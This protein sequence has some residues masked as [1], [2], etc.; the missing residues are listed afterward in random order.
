MEEY[1]K[2]TIKDWAVEDRPREKMLVKG[3]SS[4]SD[5]EL[6]AILI[7]AGS[8]NAS[9]V[10]I[11]KDILRAADNSLN[12]LGKWSVSDFTRFKGIGEAKAIAIVSALELGR[13]RNYS[14]AISKPS[15]TSS[16]DAYELLQPIVADLAHE[17]FW[18]LFLNRANKVVAKERLSQ[19][20]VSGTVIDAKMVMKRG[21]ELLASS[22]IVCHNHPSGQVKPSEADA[23]IT[24]K[25]MEAGRLMDIPVL[26][27]VIIAGS[28]YYSFMDNG[29]E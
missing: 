7:R 9:A 19:G 28:D 4:L 18:A 22:I 15:V 14:D 23:V 8:I 1:K 13:R 26:D 12:E 24:R 6:I 29:F 2:Q 3:T 17:E 10:E 25:L 11:S 20:G 5:S 21:I 16:R 27:H